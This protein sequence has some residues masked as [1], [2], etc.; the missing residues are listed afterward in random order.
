M[1]LTVGKVHSGESEPKTGAYLVVR[2]SAKVG[3]DSMF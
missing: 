1:L 3:V 2:R